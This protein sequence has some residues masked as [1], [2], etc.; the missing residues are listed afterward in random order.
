M[1][2]FASRL[3]RPHPI[4]RDT[5]EENHLISPGYLE[6]YNK[7]VL[8]GL[9]EGIK[10]GFERGVERG[11]ERATRHARALLARQIRLRFGSSEPVNAL[12]EQCQADDLDAVAQAILQHDSIESLRAFVQSQVSGR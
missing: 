10:R 2:I 1:Y 9:E 11:V 7:G 3:F 4:R 8:I 12:L 5:R 6:I